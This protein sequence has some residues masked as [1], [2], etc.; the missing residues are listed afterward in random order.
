MFGFTEIEFDF[1]KTFL[2][3]MLTHPLTVL[4]RHPVDPER[5]NVPDY[6]SVVK[7]PMDLGTI[8]AKL[9]HD[10]YANSDEF[11]S[12]VDLVW[13]NALLYHKR[14]KNICYTIA[15]R[16]KEKSDKVLGEIPKTELDEW[17][18]RFRRANRKLSNFL[19]GPAPHEALLPRLP[20][21]A[22]H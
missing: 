22:I 13:A 20:E 17:N 3:K 21:L 7:T 5:D 16:L 18:R 9:S 8:A 2:D 12:D 4:F 10:E 19:K 15:G 11:H 6:R 14:S 1:C